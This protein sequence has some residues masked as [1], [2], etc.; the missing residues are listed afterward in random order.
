VPAL[1]Y[2]AFRRSL[3]KGDILPVYY[4][5][6]DEDYLKDEAVRDLLTRAVDPGARDFNLDRRRAADVTADAFSTMVLTPPMMA[7]RRAVVLTEVEAIQQKRARAQSLKRAVVQ[8]LGNPVPE[9]LL[10]LVQ[11]G[12][13][14]TDAELARNATAVNVAP[15]EPGRVLKWILHKAGQDGLALDEAGARH[16]RDAVGSDLALLAAELGKLKGAMGNEPAGVTEVADLVGVRHGETTHDFVD[17]VTGRRFAAAASMIG[18]LLETPGTS[19]VRLVMLLGTAFAGVS[20]A[21]AL[22]D[23]GASPRSLEQKLKDALFEARPA[24]L[25]NWKDEAT[26]WASDAQAWRLDELEDAAAALLRADK[27][28]KSTSLASEADVVRDVILAMG[29]AAER[30]A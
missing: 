14:K 12:G 29:A 21:R 19:G 11:S 7:E 22:L 8:Y 5:H 15:L 24:N 16:L 10:I 1:D 18:R 23:D 17:A 3:Q 28:L 26:R 30:A 20:L 9:T 27:R 2:D 4:F 25:R 13:E 6:G